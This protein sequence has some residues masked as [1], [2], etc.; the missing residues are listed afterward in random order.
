MNIH[1]YHAKQLRWYRVTTR[2]V[3]WFYT[4]KAPSRVAEGL[5][6]QRWRE[7]ADPSG[8]PWESRGVK[9]GNSPAEITRPGR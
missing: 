7:G 5:G 8:R 3:R 6:G 4:S 2:V 1:E 9:I